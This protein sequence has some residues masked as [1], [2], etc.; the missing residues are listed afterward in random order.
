MRDT[1]YRTHT[2]LTCGWRTHA[3]AAMLG[4]IVCRK[5]SEPAPL[6]SHERRQRVRENAARLQRL[7]GWL[8]L[9]RHESDRGAGDVAVRL[10]S[11]AS[12][13][14]I[15]RWLTRLLK[16]CACPTD[17]AAAVL[18]ERHPYASAVAE[19]PPQYYR[20]PRDLSRL[21]RAR[22]DRLVITVATGRIH[23]RL[24]ER[25]TG[26]YMQAYAD[27]IGADFVALTGVTQCWWGLEKMRIR[28]LIEQYERAMFI[29][30]DVLI[31]GGAP[32]LFNVVPPG[33][34]GMH[35]DYPHCKAKNGLAWLEPARRAM[36]DSQMVDF[37]GYPGALNTGV[38][39][40][41]REQAGIW[42]P[43]QNL[44]DFPRSHVDE[45]LWVEWLAW[46]HPIF[47]IPTE[48]NTQWWFIDFFERAKT[49]WFVHLANCPAERRS[50]MIA[51]FTKHGN[52][53]EVDR[54]GAVSR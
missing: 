39:V 8:W 5:C 2:C 13:R 20:V 49:A 28:P 15:E 21:P 38:V 32:D 14:E 4:K 22:R 50:E 30:A 25:D 33:H 9:L 36:L 1:V 54:Q 43:W 34:V 17:A 37:Y 31:R 12:G 7:V 18:N 42:T 27:R 46:R 6:K 35:D 41:D 29:D 24:L 52:V 47:G 26:P 11:A 10:L 51:R 19:R 23:E 53:R 3:P 44:A 48:F 45:Q 16:Q 40:T